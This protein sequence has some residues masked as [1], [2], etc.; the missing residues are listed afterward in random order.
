[1]LPRCAKGRLQ[2]DRRDQPRRSCHHGL[3]LGPSSTS[4]SWLVASCDDIFPSTY[5]SDS[6]ALHPA[7]PVMVTFV[8]CSRPSAAV[9]SISSPFA[10]IF[11]SSLDSAS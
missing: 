1:M 3:P 2:A 5:H 10:S 9:N 7:S 6:A 4:S 8:T 11:L